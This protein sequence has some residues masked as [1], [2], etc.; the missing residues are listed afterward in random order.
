MWL[1]LA[2]AAAV[3]AG[4]VNIAV[5]IGMKNVDTSLS[6][7]LR[8]V[9]VLIFSLIIT[10]I[11]GGFGS[12]SNL[13]GIE[14]LYIV[15]SGV[16]VGASWL[17]L[18]KALQLGD[19]HKVVPIDKLST[20][21][22]M[23]FAIIFFNESFWWLTF[24]CMGL[25]VFG[26]MLMVIKTEKREEIR[27]KRNG[28][29]INNTNTIHD[30][31]FT[32]HEKTNSKTWLLFA[33]LALVFAVPATLLA[34]AGM[35]NITAQLGTFLRT[36][37]VLVFAFLIVAFKKRRFGGFA[38][39]KLFTKTNWVFIVISGVLTGVSWLC[40]F[41]ALQLGYASVVVPIDKLSIV[42][43]VA[44]SFVLF[45]EKPTLRA[46]VGLVILVAGTL[47]LLL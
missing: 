5:K 39:I 21:L 18:Y 14:W 12:L 47:L 23:V 6:T 38:E 4:F 7:F 31:R 17:C 40:F 19:A 45:K 16:C 11:V 34:K 44:F 30:S 24:V 25:M 3:A 22:T 28:I 35:Q 43:T 13:N 27:D 33:V 8:T 2:I 9:V 26:T 20:V 15:L 36:A 37:V 42:I 46:V 32:I 1:V 29:N 41:A 10:L